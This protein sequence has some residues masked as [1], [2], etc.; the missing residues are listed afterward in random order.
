MR[1]A[2]QFIV[3]LLFFFFTAI[4]ESRA[5]CSI[6]TKTAQQMGEGPARGLNGGILYLAAAPLMI[7]GF[8]GYKWYQSNR[9]S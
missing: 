3:V 6:C 2:S 4:S 9:G 1:K 8:I 5:Q 7:L